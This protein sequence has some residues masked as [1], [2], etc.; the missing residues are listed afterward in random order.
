MSSQLHELLAEHVLKTKA[1]FTQQA[2]TTTSADFE[3]LRAA[4]DQV[5]TQWSS[6]IP[7]LFLRCASPAE[8]MAT[9]NFLTNRCGIRGFAFSLPSRSQLPIVVGRTEAPASRWLEMINLR[10]WFD[11][12]I[13]KKGEGNPAD[14]ARS[15]IEEIGRQE[16]ES[17]KKRIPEIKEAGG[18]KASVRH[19]AFLPAHYHA[20]AVD[21]AD[22]LLVSFFQSIGLFGAEEYRGFFE[23]FRAGGWWWTLEDIVVWCDNPTVLNVTNNMLHCL[24]G[25]AVSFDGKLDVFAVNGRIVPARIICEPVTVADVQFEE[26]AEIRAILLNRLGLDNYIKQSNSHVISSDDYGV[27]YHVETPLEIEPF[28]CLVEVTNSSPEPDGTFR[29][30]YLRVPPTMNSAR[31]AVAWSFDLREHEYQPWR[32]T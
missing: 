17:L 6:E 4:V 7:S 1:E 32:E 24:D 8:A 18:G 27:L 23:A 12:A 26:N 31:Q 16:A 20:P 29:K 28:M 13:P 3:R 22:L 15:I 2:L 30:Y 11:A 5:Y 21:A 19:S 10:S 14:M 25:P 9:V